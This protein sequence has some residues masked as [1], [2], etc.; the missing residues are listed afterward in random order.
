VIARSAAVLERAG[1]RLDVTAARIAAVDPAVQLARG[2][3]ITRRS[4]GSL[5]RSV[6]D[7]S[8]GELISTSVAD[9]TVSS[10]VTTIFTGT[11]KD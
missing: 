4:D 6:A 11:D 2:W 1:G 8:D 5:V 9:G 7:V 10:T 3:S